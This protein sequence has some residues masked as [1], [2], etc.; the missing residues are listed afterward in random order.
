MR[1]CFL[2]TAVMFLCACVPLAGGVYDITQAQ[3]QAQPSPDNPQIVPESE[4][5]AVTPSWKPD[6]VKIN[7]RPATGGPYIVQVGDTLYKISRETG[8]S[9]S[10]IAATNNLAEPY[11]L[12]VGQR[13]TIPKGTYHMVGV[14]ETGIAIARAYDVR[15][16]DIVTLNRLEEPYILKAG[17]RL[18]LPDSTAR[19]LGSIT[20]VINSSTAASAPNSPSAPISQAGGSLSPEARAARFSLNIDDIVTGG[21]PATASEVTATRK[22]ASLSTPIA[23]PASFKGSFA[24]P[25]QGRVLSRF[26]S[27]GG[28]KVNDGINIAATAGARV[29]ASGDGVIVYSGNEIDV[30]GGLVLIDHGDGW[31]TAYGHLGSLRVARGDK[32]RSGQQ[33]GSVGETG[34]VSSPQ[35]HF[36]IRKDRKP[37]DP[38]TQLPK[39]NF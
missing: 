12:L 22:G 8:A 4:P 7:P 18:R 36:Q 23:R 28:G 30:F 33:I 34:Y 9:V 32:V 3:A 19:E 1:Q 2:P 17:Q 24:W 13:L 37:L 21:E 11:P 39:S 35:L 5:I 20:P 14:G 6:G 25:L 29:T 31:V 26:G 16:S 38:T 15:W 27:K 10:D